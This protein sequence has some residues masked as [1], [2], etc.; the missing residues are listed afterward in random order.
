[1]NKKQLRKQAELI[2]R[3]RKLEDKLISQRNQGG[4]IRVFNPFR[5][6]VK[7]Y[8]KNKLALTKQ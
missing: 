8:V 6:F 2:A 4:D 5:N 1:M 7:R 3:R